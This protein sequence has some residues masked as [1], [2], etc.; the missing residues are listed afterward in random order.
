L[1]KLAVIKNSLKVKVGYADH[2]E[3]TNPLTIALPSM[4]VLM[5]ADY[6]EK[7]LTME[8]DTLQLEDCI[9]ALNPA[10][11][12]QMVKMIRDTDSFPDPR[13]TEF[14]LTEREKKYRINSKKVIL[15]AGKLKAG[16]VIT[17]N[18]I[19]MLRTGE[20]YNELLDLD[21]IVGK[22]LITD[23][24]KHKIIKKEYLK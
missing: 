23:I 3:V 24:D 1:N 18:E 7:H 5:G 12:S 21:E 8:R 19:V 15:A 16:T 10:E 17:E 14:E 2:I 13:N 22:Q 4:A 20:V 6:I 11:F 9:S